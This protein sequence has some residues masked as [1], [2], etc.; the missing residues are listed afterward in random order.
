MK[1][2]KDTIRVIAMVLLVLVLLIM[3]IMFTGC[4]PE[5]S[6]AGD[7][8]AIIRMP[9][10]EIVEGRATNAYYNSSGVYSI[11][12]DGTTYKTHMANVV[13]ISGDN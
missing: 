2:N 9:N 10:G 12:I 1:N 7:E 11:T 13:V 8:W 3:A 6:A 4:A 5:A